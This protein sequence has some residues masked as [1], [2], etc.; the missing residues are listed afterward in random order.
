MS[1]ALVWFLC[2]TAVYYTGVG[3]GIT[4]VSTR[5]KAPAEALI[6]VS[7]HSSS[8]WEAGLAWYP[9]AGRVQPYWS[10]LGG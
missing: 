9:G 2:P 6:R 8:V 1:G 3:A 5:V 10:H 4:G 7:N